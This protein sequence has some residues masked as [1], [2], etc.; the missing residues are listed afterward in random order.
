MIKHLFLDMDGTLLNSQGT[1]SQKNISVLQ[2]SAL[3]TTLVSA[4]APIE[5]AP[6]IGQL[7]LTAPQIGFNGGIIFQPQ[8]DAPTKIMEAHPIKEATSFLLLSWLA[9]NFPTISLSY[10]T[11]DHWLTTKNDAGIELETKLT[12]LQPTLTTA[13][14]LA[15]HAQAGIFKV[16]L[17]VFDKN[18]LLKIQAE[19]T[20]LNL[21]G[22]V[23]QQ[24]GTMYL[25][26]TSERAQKSH[27]LA[28]I[29]DQEQLLPEET[30]AFGDGHNDLP[31]FA[32]VGTPI[33]MDNAL[34]VIK[35][36]GKFITKSNDEDGVA[37]GIE[38]FIQ[39]QPSA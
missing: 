5:M 8:L 3:P 39:G 6:A 9:E 14:D 34:E 16:M 2:Q 30:A 37:Y 32:T 26:I 23:I 7:G 35:S 1:V 4:R 12:G 38:T 22:I 17:I 20:N 29:M 33:V 15:Q 21:A 13:T 11:K 19:L 10:Y 18:L 36:A 27:G 25:E 24:S 31:M 28:F